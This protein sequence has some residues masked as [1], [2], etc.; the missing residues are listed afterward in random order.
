MGDVY[1]DSD[2]AIKVWITTGR[3]QGTILKS[4]VDDTFTPASGIKVNVE[5]VDPGALLNAVV[6]GR[7]PDVVLSVAANL[8]VDYAL[9]N[10]AEDLTQFDGWEEVFS[11]FS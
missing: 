2:E 11:R 7:G 3:D 8:P 1:A 9:R 5:I 10:A 6:A 4:M